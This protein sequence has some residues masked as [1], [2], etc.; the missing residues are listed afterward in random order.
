MSLLDLSESRPPVT[1]YRA[2]PETRLSAGRAWASS[3][4][5]PGT[6]QLYCD[7]DTRGWVILLFTLAAIIATIFSE[8]ARE[9]AIRL[10]IVFYVLAPV[11]A[12]FTACEHNAGI[13]VEAANNPRVAALLNM[14][15]NGF[16]YFYVGWRSA[17]G[18]VVLSGF[19]T[20]SIADTLPLIVEAFRAFISI[21]AWKLATRA[22]ETEYPAGLRPQIEESSFPAG[23]PIAVAAVIAGHYWILVIIGQIAIWRS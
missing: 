4:L 21:H 9:V 13:D 17:V 10:L 7:A 1:Q 3:M 12:Y 18:L 14:T 5:L 15:T 8:A 6:G 2:L 16:G 19:M 11:D 20:R 23:V 22:R